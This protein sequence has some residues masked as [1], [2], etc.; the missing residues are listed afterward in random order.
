MNDSSAMFWATEM[1]WMNSEAGAG[2]LGSEAAEVATA[3]A[4]RRKEGTSMVNTWDSN[5][6]KHVAMALCYKF[7]PWSQRTQ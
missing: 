5:T 2:A 7:Q 4:E 3:T 1:V 6:M